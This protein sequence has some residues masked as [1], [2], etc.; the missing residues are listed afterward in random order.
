MTF[1]STEI[2][3]IIIQRVWREEKHQLWG[4]STTK[5]HAE[6]EKIIKMTEK[7]WPK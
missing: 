2:Q 3:V 6:G 4:I 7:E 5:D 1:K